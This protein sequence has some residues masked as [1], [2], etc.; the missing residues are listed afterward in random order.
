VISDKMQNAVT[1]Y[2]RRKSCLSKCESKT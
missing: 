1:K 2:I